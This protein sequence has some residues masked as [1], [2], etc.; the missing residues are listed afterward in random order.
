MNRKKIKMGIELK[1]DLGSREIRFCDVNGRGKPALLLSLVQDDD[2]GDD[3]DIYIMMK[4][5][6]ATKNHHFLSARAECRRREARCLLGLS[7]RRPALA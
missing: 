5:V 1:I 4:C 6:C 3:D 2:D 7:G